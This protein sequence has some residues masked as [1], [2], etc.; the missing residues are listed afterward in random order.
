M[1]DVESTPS[2]IYLR[3]VKKQLYLKNTIKFEANLL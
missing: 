2:R 3:I 1:V